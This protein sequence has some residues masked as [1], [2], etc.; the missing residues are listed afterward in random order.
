M[1]ENN[2]SEDI[3]YHHN[4]EEVIDHTCDNNGINVPNTEEEADVTPIHSI[5]KTNDISIND[6]EN[7]IP[8]YYIPFLSS[9]N[10]ENVS[11]G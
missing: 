7:F 1:D 10:H 4:S 9:N 5:N 8:E 6:G 11:P 3:S 2:I